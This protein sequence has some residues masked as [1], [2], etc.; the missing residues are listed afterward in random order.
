MTK[1]T[2]RTFLHTLGAGA[3]ASSAVASREAHAQPTAPQRFVIREDRFGRMFPGLR[4]FAESSPRLLGRVARDRQAG[5]RAG[6]R[7]D[8]LAGPI[9]LIVDPALNVNNPNNTTHTAGTTFMGQFMDHDMTFDLDLARSASRPSPTDSPNTR[10]PRSTSTRSMP[11]D[12]RRP[13]SSTCPSR[14]SLSARSSSGSSTAASSR[15][16]RA[17]RTGAAIIGDPRNDENLMIAGLHAA[18]LLFHNRAVDRIRPSDRRIDVRRGVRARP[19]GSRRWHY[20]WMIVHEFLPLFV[21]QALVDDILRRGRKLLPAA[22]V[23]VHARSSSRA[24]RTASATPW[25]GPRTGRTCLAT[26]MPAAGAPFFGMIFDPAGEGQADPVD[27]RGGARARAALH[28]LADVLR[29]RRRARPGGRRNARQDVRPNKLIDTQDLHAA[30]QP[31]ARRDRLGR[32]A[33]L[34]AA[35]QP[36]PSRHLAR[37]L[38]ARASRDTWGCPPLSR[39][40]FPELRGL[41]PGPR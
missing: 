23:G 27:L 36:A 5:R 16:C 13:A 7:D 39:A 38:P 12:R 9:A 20:Q 24:L 17:T 28:R 18:F 6:R 15:I 3:V 19:S 1:I 33:D 14:R 29:F 35:A 31:A 10:T 34:A 22:T 30:V 2:R 21:G 41:R 40:D 8:L 11:A 26:S 25:S 37:S 4:P 32:S